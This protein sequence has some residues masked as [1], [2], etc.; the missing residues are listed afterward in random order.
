M[1]LSLLAVAA[2]TDLE[3]NGDN[4]SSNISG[5]AE[6]YEGTWWVNEKQSREATVE[7]NNAAFFFKEMPYDGIIAQLFPD[8][9]VTSVSGTGYVVPFTFKAYTDRSY[10]YV[11][12]PEEWQFAANIDGNDCIV[13]IT[14]NPIY[15]VN[16]G[17]WGSYS[18]QN[19]VFTL[20]L[21]AVSYKVYG[22]PGSGGE[23][24]PTDLRLKFT[25][26]TPKK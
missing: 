11:V 15:N 22:I 4:M 20:F 7:V 8:S 2:C 19:G 24:I 9:K 16:S 26:S 18:R 6:L 1:S 25:S 14:F 21:R 3:N 23:D 10:L 13:H 5:S 12:Q 17:S